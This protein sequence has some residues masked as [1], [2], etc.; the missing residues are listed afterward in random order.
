MK[1]NLEISLNKGFVHFF[2]HMRYE[3]FYILLV[4]RVNRRLVE[5]CSCSGFFI[6]LI[7]SLQQPNGKIRPS[8]FC[9]SEEIGSKWHV[10]GVP[11]WGLIEVWDSNWFL[12]LSCELS[13]SSNCC[14]FSKA[15]GK[16]THTKFTRERRNIFIQHSG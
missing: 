16:Q 3:L 6:L 7:L 15:T 11:G 2:G 1:K 12:S 8:S 10:Q 13:V 9:A 14:H 5:L 4:F